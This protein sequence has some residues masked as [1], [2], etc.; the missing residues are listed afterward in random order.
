MSI[1]LDSMIALIHCKQRDKESLQDYI[2]KFK[3]ARE[4]FQSHLGG[5]FVMKKFL[6]NI[7]GYDKDDEEKIEELTEK[8]DEQFSSYLYMVNSDQGKYG[9]VIKRLHSQKVLQ[10]DQYPR[11]IIEANNVLSTHKFDYIKG[12]GN[13]PNSSKKEKRNR[14]KQEDK[15]NEDESPPLSFTQ[16]EGKCYCCGK[17]GHKSPDCYS[18]SKIPRE[19]WAINKTNKAQ[20]ATV[21]KENTTNE[22]N[23]DEDVESEKYIG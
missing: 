5:V 14:E 7:T 1:I 22:S 8:A 6:E 10:N 20:M 23:K 12:Q 13:K 18:K 17:A 11:T 19:E 3:V 9:T 16:M 2:R 21:K 4:I 15:D